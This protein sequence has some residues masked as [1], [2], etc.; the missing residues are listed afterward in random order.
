MHSGV[1]VRGLHDVFDTNRRPWI[2]ADNAPADEIAALIDSCPSG[3]LKY[4]R[5]DK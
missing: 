2:L 3:A 1:C 5:K 4:I